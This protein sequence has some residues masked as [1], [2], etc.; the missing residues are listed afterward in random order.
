MR[1]GG[2]SSKAHCRYEIVVNDTNIIPGRLTAR[3]SRGESHRQALPELPLTTGASETNGLQER[4]CHL[5][6]LPL[7]KVTRVYTI[8]SRLSSNR[9]YALALRWRAFPTPFG[10]LQESMK[11]T[12]RLHACCGIMH[13]PLA[14]AFPSVSCIGQRDDGIATQ[15]IASAGRVAGQAQTVVE[16]CCQRIE[17]P[18]SCA[19]TRGLDTLALSDFMNVG[20]PQTAT[21]PTQ[22]RV[23]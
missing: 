20:S 10:S 19:Q 9:E 13:T 15:H 17:T 6:F 11:S 14:G 22:T 5:E 16:P 12:R 21:R 3:A 1:S 2:D 7:V 18:E 8:S 23:F 4:C